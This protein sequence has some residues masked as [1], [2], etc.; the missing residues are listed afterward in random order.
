MAPKK[1]IGRPPH[2]PRDQD[3]AIVKALTIFGLPQ[4][5]IANHLKID[6]TTLVK[7]YPEELHT[8]RGE[9]M[10]LAAGGLFDKLKKQDEW[11]IKWVMGTL[12]KKYGWVQR[13]EVGIDLTAA[14]GGADF[15]KLSPE[16]F[17]QLVDLL[18]LAGVYLPGAATAAVRPA[19]VLIGHG[20]GTA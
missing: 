8:A 6:Q 13:H 5:D 14:L 7:H 18:A 15:S 3:R 1:R 20:R 10:A 17:D 4:P 16:Q 9:V 2:E 12:G 19:P 11:A